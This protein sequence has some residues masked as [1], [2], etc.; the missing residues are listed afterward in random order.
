MSTVIKKKVEQV[1]PLPEPSVDL[2]ELAETVRAEEFATLKQV[3][4]F[5]L[6]Y[7]TG[8]SCRFGDAYGN[9]NYD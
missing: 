8:I 5:R 1:K 9:C 4:E 6:Q 3:R 2:P 7:A